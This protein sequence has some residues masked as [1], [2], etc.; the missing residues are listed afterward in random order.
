MFNSFHKA[1]NGLC[2][3]DFITWDNFDELL[4]PATLEIKE[5]AVKWHHFSRPCNSHIKFLHYSEKPN[6]LQQFQCLQGIQSM[7]GSTLARD[8]FRTL[9]VNPKEA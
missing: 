7:A 4:I 9:K 3:A 1:L 5:G 6:S 2:K 8:E